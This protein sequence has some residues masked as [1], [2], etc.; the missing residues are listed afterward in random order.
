MDPHCFC[1]DCRE[2]WDSDGSIDLELIQRGNEQAL[3]T[4]A[5]ILP[6]DMIPAPLPPV[7]S[8]LLPTRSNGGGIPLMMDSDDGPVPLSLPKPTPRDITNETLEERL[9]MDLS[10]L[11]ADIHRDL[12]ITMD[13]ARNLICLPEAERAEYMANLRTEED[14]LWRKL[15]A[16]ELLLA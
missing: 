3:W 12:I 8:I 15:D 9:K 5:Q 1:F 11:R 7:A 6:A 13:K 10:L 14:K 2:L 16:I 4:Y